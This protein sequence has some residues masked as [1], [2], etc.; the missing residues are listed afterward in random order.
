MRAAAPFEEGSVSIG[1]ALFD[2][3]FWP[4]APDF[5]EKHAAV[6]TAVDMNS[7]LF[8]LWSSS[9]NSN[10]CV[11]DAIARLGFARVCPACCVD[12]EVD[13]SPDQVSPK[14]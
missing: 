13:Q 12:V 7:R 1:S 11:C 14:A 5:R 10:A 2:P 8:T 3:A 4:A 9:T 6:A